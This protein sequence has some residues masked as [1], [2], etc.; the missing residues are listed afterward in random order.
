MSVRTWIRSLASIQ[1]DT[2]LLQFVK[3]NDKSTKIQTSGVRA[4]QEVEIKEIPTLNKK[5]ILETLDTNTQY[6]WC[7]PY[8]LMQLFKMCMCRSGRQS[9][10]HM[11]RTQTLAEN[12]ILCF[13]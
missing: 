6:I 12:P 7:Q 10:R 1:D 9:N 13:V 11:E 2:T 3:V 5:L 8:P 4:L